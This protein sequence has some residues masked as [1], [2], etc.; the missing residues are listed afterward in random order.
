M[1]EA[2]FPMKAEIKF[3]HMNQVLQ[4]K[5]TGTVKVDEPPKLLQWTTLRQ[6]TKGLGG[7]R[8]CVCTKTIQPPLLFPPPRKKTQVKGKR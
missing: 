8:G 7:G 5:V 3:G 6:I 2:V 1:K 4:Q